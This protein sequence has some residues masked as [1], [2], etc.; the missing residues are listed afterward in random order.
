[1]ETSKTTPSIKDRGFLRRAKDWRVLS[2]V[3]NGLSKYA[4]KYDVDE[5]SIPLWGGNHVDFDPVKQDL[6]MIG[7][8]GERKLVYTLDGWKKG[9]K[10]ILKEEIRKKG[11]LS[12]FEF[13]KLRT[14]IDSLSIRNGVNIAGIRL[15]SD[16]TVEY[17]RFGARG[18]MYKIGS[19]GERVELDRRGWK[20]YSPAIE[21]EIRRQEAEIKDMKRKTAVLEQKIFDPKNGL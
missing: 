5:V 9:F 21:E 17:K 18:K 13:L 19:E 2:G 7:P 4:A 6:C 14:R 20:Q 12:D 11:Q 16:E 8:N 10:K 15:P 3:K 1:M